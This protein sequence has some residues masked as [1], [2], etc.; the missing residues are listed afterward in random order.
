MAAHIEWIG[1]VA[2][3]RLQHGKVQAIDR[4]LL[5]ELDNA[6]DAVAA[7]RALVLTGTGSTFSAGVDLFQVLEGTA[8]DTAAFL[9]RFAAAL[10]RLFSWPAPVVAAVNGHAIAGGAL[11]AWCGDLRVMVEGT[12]RIGVPELRVGVPFPAAALEIL[13]FATAGGHLQ[14]LAYLGRTYDAAEALARGLVDDV[15]PTTELQRR[16]LDTAAALAALSPDAFA[17][18]KRAIRRPALE[19]MD[20]AA[21]D[22]HQAVAIWQTTITREAIREYLDRRFPGRF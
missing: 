19:A 10:R 16:A 7:A 21:A 11:L 2:L 6:L 22:D 8:D 14:T 5:D 17:L 15:C 12:S 3:L 13:R 20:R 4:A 9:S 18:T 1:P